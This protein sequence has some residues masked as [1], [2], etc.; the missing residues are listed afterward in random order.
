MVDGEYFLQFTIL[1]LP[2]ETFD[3][4]LKQFE[5]KPAV[6]TEHTA[7]TKARVLSSHM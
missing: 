7:T 2:L 4:N 6:E 3:G 5:Y 1:I